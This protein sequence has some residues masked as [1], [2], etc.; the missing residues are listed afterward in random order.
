[1]G[2]EKKARTA[3]LSVRR[4]ADLY[5]NVMAAVGINRAFE[6][7]IQAAEQKLTALLEI[8]YTVD[9]ML[10]FGRTDNAD[11]IE[12]EYS[13]LEIFGFKLALVQAITGD[14]RTRGRAGH[15]RIK[16]FLLPLAS[17]LGIARIVEKES[18]LP[19]EPAEKLA[20][21]FDDEAAKPDKADDAVKEAMK[22]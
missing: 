21:S 2:E 7:R 15:G 8:E 12:A 18:A 3:T 6:R 19:D 4:L 11:L 13:D 22:E 1:M 16:R 20:L 14:G 17:E 9:G 5:H 10:T